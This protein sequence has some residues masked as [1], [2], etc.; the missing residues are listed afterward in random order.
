[1]IASGKQIGIIFDPRAAC[2][3]DI[4]ARLEL[5]EYA[6]RRCFLICGKL[7]FHVLGKTR[8]RVGQNR[9]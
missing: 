7:F 2:K 1:M 8:I 4:V 3:I 9:P 6:V 5:V